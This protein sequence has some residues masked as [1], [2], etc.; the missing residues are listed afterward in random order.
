MAENVL[1][2]GKPRLGWLVD[3][4]ESTPHVAVMVEDTGQQ[5]EVTV[6]TKGMLDRDDPYARWFSA[7]ISFGDD[8]DRTKFAYRPPS[9]I[10]V[11]GKDGPVVLV[12]CRSSGHWMNLPGPGQGKIVASFAILGARHLNY[13]RINGL[14]A[15]LPALAPWTGLR[16]VRTEPKTDGTGK[17]QRVEVTLDS[18]PPQALS[19]RMNLALRPTWRTSY[20]DTVGTFAAHDVVELMTATKDPRPWEDHID[21]LAAIRELL[22][23]SAWRRFGFSRLAVNRGDDPERVLSGDAV[24]ERWAEAST[25][26]LPKHED[27]SKTPHFLFSYEDIGVVGVR[28]WIRIREHFQR[29]LRPLVGL[30]DQPNSY[31]EVKLVQSGIALEAL[32]YQLAVDQGK[33]TPGK[34]LQQT[35]ADALRTILDDMVYVPLTESEAWVVRSTDHYRGTKHADN[36]PPDPIE[37]ANTMRENLLVARFWLA[38]RLGVKRKDLESRLERDPMS[39]PYVA[40][41]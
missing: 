41:E 40:R 3:G 7:G 14:R 32:G 37:A 8:P 22:S 23:L 17:V 28:R 18:P 27:W 10:L 5:I 4:D 30:T 31:L 25:H 12:G 16:S 33:V 39:N 1:V 9:N 11:E 21:Q 34:R 29:G 26:R 36:Q 20:P 2:P 35:Y 6:P 19:R 15:E 13:S 24:G 38:G